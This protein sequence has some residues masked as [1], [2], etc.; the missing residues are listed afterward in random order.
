[1]EW[2]EIL[3][4]Q[5]NAY[6]MALTEFQKAALA[7][8]QKG[9]EEHDDWDDIDVIAEMMDELLDLHNYGDHEKVPDELRREIQGFAKYM[10]KR[11]QY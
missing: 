11:L 6:T 2:H 8:H 10:W 4:T 1:M 9:A 3:F 7:K 5:T